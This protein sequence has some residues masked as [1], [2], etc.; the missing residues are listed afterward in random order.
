MT[1]YKALRKNIRDA[2]EK[3]QKAAY[4]ASYTWMVAVVSHLQPEAYRAAAEAAREYAAALDAYANNPEI[5]TPVEGG[6][7]RGLPDG[8]CDKVTTPEVA[9]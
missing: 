7:K 8:H 1:D 5:I 4:T 6:W 9:K 3:M 2:E